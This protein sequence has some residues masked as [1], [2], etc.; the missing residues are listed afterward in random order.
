MNIKAIAPWFG[1]KRTLAPRIVQELGPHSAYWE[2]FCGSMAVLFAKRPSPMET[3]C[4][5][6]GDLINLTRVL[7]SERCSELWER[8]RR[9]LM[10]DEHFADAKTTCAETD[11]VVAPSIQGVG[12]EH[13]ERAYWYLVM[14]WMGRNGN[15]GT[16][17]GNVTVAA[18]YTSNGGS[19]GFRWLQAVGSIPAW[20]ERLQAV[21]IKQQDGIDLL[22]R[23]EDSPK[24]VIY[25]DPPYLKKGTKY[26]H[27]F[28][29]A[30]HERLSAVLSRFRHTRVVVADYDD[31]HL[32][33]LYPG[34]TKVDCA[35]SKG[36]ANAG[37]RDAD[38]QTVLAPEVLLINQPSLAT[39]QQRKMFD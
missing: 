6:H 3:V 9:T 7:A 11:A 21:H 37:K 4:D 1:G 12:D 33:R 29:S 27:D 26:I 10:H 34:W 39:S 23:V 35:M 17:M 22:E 31:P 32:D 25:A 13:L 16:G 38:G 2:P 20:H 14:S 24:S 30:D 15:S 28:E 36:L 8:S 19:G 18:R 5:L